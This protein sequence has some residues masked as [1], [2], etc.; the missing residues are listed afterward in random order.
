MPGGRLHLVRRLAAEAARREIT[1]RIWIAAAACCAVA[2]LLL[3]CGAALNV[4]AWRRR[5]RKIFEQK[6]E[7]F[8][9][10]NPPPGATASEQPDA[11]HHHQEPRTTAA[12]GPVVSETTSRS[13]NMEREPLVVSDP[14]GDMATSDELQEN[15]RKRPPTP[16]PRRTARPRQP[17][18]RYSTGTDDDDRRAR[19][20]AR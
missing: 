6:N 7:A 16:S 9:A 10:A 3:L 1:P 13:M 14:P 19:A 2:L 11:Q 12:E 8:V 20:R 17:S 15:G 5:R 18:L 4:S